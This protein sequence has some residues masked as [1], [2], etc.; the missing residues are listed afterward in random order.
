[1]LSC[2]RCR[3]HLRDSEVIC[4]FCTSPLKRSR[5]PEAL[6]LGLAAVVLAACYG[7]GPGSM[8]D[9]DSAAD[10]YDNDSDGWTAADGDCDEEQ[11]SVNPDA[12][13]VCDDG[14]DNDC[15]TE[16]D[17]DDSDCGN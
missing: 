11:P 4:P 13:E 14:V 17:G 2:T 8:D 1:M 16:T 12:A 3:R 5:V 9:D 15:D 10:Q 6:T 7:P